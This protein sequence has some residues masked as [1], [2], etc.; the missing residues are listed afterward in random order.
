MAN[1]NCDAEIQAFQSAE[2]G[3]DVR[4]A[5]VSLAR[6]VVEYANSGINAGSNLSALISQANSA[7]ANLNGLISR[8]DEIKS[9]VDSVNSQIDTKLVNASNVV[10]DV[11]ALK[12]WKTSVEAG[13]TAVVV[14]VD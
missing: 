2:Y 8:A 9:H 5:L 12:A 4:A 14:K 1:L 13:S 11:T 10:P 6:K 7:K 3:E